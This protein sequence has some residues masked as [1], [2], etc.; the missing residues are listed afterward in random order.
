MSTQRVLSA[1]ALAAIVLSAWGVADAQRRRRDPPPVPADARIQWTL[2]VSAYDDHPATRSEVS[3]EPG[4]VTLPMSE[5]TCTYGAPN[6]ASLD[7]TNWSEMRALECRHGD[8]VVSTTGFCQIAGASWGARAGVLSLGVGAS[9]SRVTL[10][11]DCAV[12]P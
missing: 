6:R 1:L 5:W 3:S 10:T 4:R 12:L 9:P 7:A 11:L 8:G 2:I